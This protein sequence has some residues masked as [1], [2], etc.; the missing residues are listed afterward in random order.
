MLKFQSGSWEDL[1]LVNLGNS[2]V[3]QIMSDKDGKIWEEYES[4][5][6]NWAANNCLVVTEGAIYH[7]RTS[8]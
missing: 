7:I 5:P 6:D 1:Y 3:S 8:V 2:E 4:V